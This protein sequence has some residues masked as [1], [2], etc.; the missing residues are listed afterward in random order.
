MTE[1]WLVRHG[2]AAAAFD[3]DTDPPLSEKGRAQ[4]ERAAL[5][6]RSCAETEALSLIHI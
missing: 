4:A 2:E 1:I 5:A 6:L 3:Q